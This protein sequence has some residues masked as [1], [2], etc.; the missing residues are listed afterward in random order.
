MSSVRSPKNSGNF[1]VKL[2]S[3]AQLEVEMN[4]IGKKRNYIMTRKQKPIDG[5]KYSFWSDFKFESSCGIGPLTPLLSIYLE[6][7]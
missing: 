1:P 2:L 7:K 4:G 5:G 3:E 6:G